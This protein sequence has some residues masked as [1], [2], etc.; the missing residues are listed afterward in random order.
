M[1]V[2][3]FVDVRS[4][5][6]S[7]K[8]SPTPRLRFP[9]RVLVLL[10][11]VLA[12]SGTHAYD[13][14]DHVAA[15]VNPP[16]GL[17][18][19]QVPQFVS[20]GFDDNGYS[21]LPGSGGDGAMTWV[22]DLL[23]R[24]V[25]DA[26]SA[27]AATFDGLPARVAFYANSYY[28]SRY[29]SESPVYVKQSWHTALLDGHELGNHT[30]GHMD[31]QTFNTGQWL[32]EI[33]LCVDW[34]T[35]PFS[36]IELPAS[37][38][39]SAGIGMA[40][41]AIRGFR[42]PYLSYSDNLFSALKQSGFTYDSSI[43]EGWQPWVTGRSFVWPYTLD[44]GSPGNAYLAALGLKPGISS[45][46][47]LWEMP[48]YPVIVPPDS[49]LAQYGLTTSLRDKVRS[50]I[51]YFDVSVGKLPGLDTTLWVN[52]Q[53][54]R[55]EFVA[56]LK[57][58]LD[59]RLQGNRAPFLYTAHSDVYSSKY[60]APTSATVDERRA[61][62]EEFIQYALSK[63]E[64]RMRPAID[65]VQWM[66]S[67]VAIG[68]PVIP[69]LTVSIP[70]VATPPSIVNLS[71]GVG[72]AF[73]VDMVAMLSGALGMPLQFVEQ[74]AQGTVVLRG[75]NGGQLAFVPLA[76]QAGDTRANGIYAVGNG[77]FRV[78][79]NGVSL[80]IAPALLHLEQLAALLPGVV[81]NQGDS[82][83]INAT[84][85]GLTYVVQPGVA[86]QTEAAS[87]GAR[88]VTGSD[89]LT[90]FIDAAGNRQALYPAFA[91]SAGLHAALQGMDAT[92]TLSIELDGTAS[93]V[94]NG[95]R[96]TLMP[97]FTL[98][99][100]PAERAGQRVWQDGPMRYRLPVGQTPAAP[101]ASQG[102]TVRP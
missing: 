11:W 10:A 51:S 23:R 15:S 35:K 50:R 19:S 17:D 21:G 8:F 14:S 77:Q 76:L 40:R 69:R 78:V 87:G 49:V 22:T 59:E 63:R 97:D 89:G 64:V 38:D 60:A 5:Q 62:L 46:P 66:R 13:Y 100:T 84:S 16:A 70:S 95:Q 33:G 79:R 93:I 28:V 29:L 6:P 43:E 57:Y 98:G 81:A 68:T 74:N 48:S 4:Q 55:A 53:M 3:K 72:P 39:A 92:A 86:V 2:G 85:N 31:G 36:S 18:A 37:P 65:V 34:L 61:A 9:T 42:G 56:T 73:M 54:T 12:S 44:S 83:V 101:G 26:G 71:G 80:A 32:T 30:Q 90:Y 82:G 1:S 67:P 91:D 58:T 102:L 75:Y 88:L 7:E 41:E 45:F 47:G 24:R 20:I 94:F 27:N 99:T 96:Y 52:A 25:N